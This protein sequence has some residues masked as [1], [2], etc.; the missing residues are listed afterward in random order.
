[1][2]LTT[3]PSVKLW[4]SPYHPTPHIEISSEPALTSNTLSRVRFKRGKGASPRGV[5]A[6][7]ETHLQ[8]HLGRIETRLGLHKFPL[9]TPENREP[10]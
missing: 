8:D 10:P 3:K 6:D 4:H 1:M 7:P 5:S 2:R 9:Y